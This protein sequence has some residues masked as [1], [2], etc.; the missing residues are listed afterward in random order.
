MYVS[1]FYHDIVQVRCM[2]VS[3]IHCQDR[4]DLAQTAQLPASG[5]YLQGEGSGNKKDGGS[6]ANVVHALDDRQ[7]HVAE[8]HLRRRAAPLG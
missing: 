5:T 3:C 6:R 4:Q 7:L 1:I 8:H 2:A